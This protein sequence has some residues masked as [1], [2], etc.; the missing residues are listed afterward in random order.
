MVVVI[1]G[2]DRRILRED[3]DGAAGQSYPRSMR[4]RL[5]GADIVAI[6]VL[7]LLV[8]GLGS[9]LGVAAAHIRSSGSSQHGPLRVILRPDSRGSSNDIPSLQRDRVRFHSGR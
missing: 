3:D 5:H 6:V 9:G 7:A 2:L 1:Q 4:R 8:A